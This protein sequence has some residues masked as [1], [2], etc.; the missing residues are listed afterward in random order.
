MMTPFN[1]AIYQIRKRIY[2]IGPLMFSLAFA[3]NFANGASFVQPGT[4]N[5]AAHATTKA[6]SGKVDVVFGRMNE[7]SRI[8]SEPTF[9]PPVDEDVRIALGP[10]MPPPIDED[11]RI[12]LGPTMPPPIDE[13]LRIA[14]G[15]TMPPPID[16][17]LRIAA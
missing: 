12:A 11:L 5:R 6:D 2:R 13:D 8:A 10:T 1:K 14:L 7:D 9:P 15:P 4:A 17:D 3:W 16:E